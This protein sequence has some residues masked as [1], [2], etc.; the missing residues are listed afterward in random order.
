[1]M[2][3]DPAFWALVALIIFFALVLYL[4]VPRQIA[5]LLDRRVDAIR[6]ELDE[7]RRLREEAHALLA[8]YQRKAREAESEAE[9]IV[10]QARREAEAIG[11]EAKRRIADYVAGRTRLAEDKIAQAEAQALQEVR[12][13]SADLAIAAAERI[14]AQRVKGE[15]ADALIGKAI[16]EVR[17]KLH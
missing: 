16:D 8:D 13:Q 1:M 9:E 2:F 15:A 10:D 4:K 11:V 12:A 14:L 3:E 17:T 6:N 7:A 5:G